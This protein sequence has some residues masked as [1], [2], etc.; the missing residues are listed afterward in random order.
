MAL[1]A[2]TSFKSSI[3]HSVDALETARITFRAHLQGDVVTT[4]GENDDDIIQSHVIPIVYDPFPDN[5]LLRCTEVNV[6]RT[7]PVRVEWRA[8]YE[9]KTSELGGG[10]DQG[11]VP[12][13]WSL[14]RSTRKTQTQIDRDINGYPIMT[15]TKESPNPPI[16]DEICDVA[17]VFSANGRI[18][19]AALLESYEEAI[20]SDTFMGLAVGQAKIDDIQAVLSFQQGS[21]PTADIQ[22]TVLVGRAPPITNLFELNAGAWQAASQPAAYYTWHKRWRAEGFKKISGG[23]VVDAIVSGEAPV[24]KLHDPLTGAL[25]SDVNDAKWYSHRTKP[26]MPFNTLFANV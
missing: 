8:N 4:A 11:G 12:L 14:R 1:D 22:V 15:K 21:P 26:M 24:P 5:P 6:N 17:Y 7:S 9:W 13:N 2:R 3:T 18:W 25:V 23:N 20:N 10:V 19:N 16:N